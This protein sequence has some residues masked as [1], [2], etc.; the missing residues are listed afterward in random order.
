MKI[1]QIAKICGGQDGAIW[2]NLLFRFDT[3]GNCYV[4]DLKFLDTNSEALTELLVYSSFRLD[5]A[6][7][8]VPHSHSVCFGYKTLR[9]LRGG[10]RK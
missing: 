1:R 7:E 9:Q 6:E 3:K 5:R 10:Q 8:I 4:Y 2:K